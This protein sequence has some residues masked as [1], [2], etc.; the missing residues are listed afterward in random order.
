[1]KDQFDGLVAVL[2]EGGFF[3]EEAVEML[4]KKLVQEAL[5]RAGGNQSEASKALGI[6]RNT[7]QRK[8]DQFGLAGRRVRRK[9]VGGVTRKRKAS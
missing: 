4:E 6:H 2:L 3:L 8:M 1:M 5:Q 9:P 7:I